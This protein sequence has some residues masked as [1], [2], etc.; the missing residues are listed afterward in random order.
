MGQSRER[1]I[2]LECTDPIRRNIV[3]IYIDAGQGMT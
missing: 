3:G 1:M 2:R